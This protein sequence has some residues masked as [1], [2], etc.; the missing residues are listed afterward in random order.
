MSAPSGKPDVSLLSP[1]EPTGSRTTIS[2]GASGGYLFNEQ[3]L[4]RQYPPMKTNAE[5]RRTARIARRA[6]TPQQQ[7]AHALQACRLMATNGIFMRA[8]RIAAYIAA[9][10]ELDPKPLLA[11]ATRYNKNIYLPILQ[12]STHNSL[13]FSHYVPG[14]ELIKNQFNIPEPNI[15]KRSP[16]KTWTLDIVLMPLVA[17]D[18][19]GHRV[20]M[21]G[22]YYDRTFA[23]IKHH[24]QMHRPLL[25]GYAHECQKSSHINVQQ[26]DIPLDGVVTEKRFYKNF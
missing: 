16:I 15:R 26:W 18:A 1:L 19:Y 24:K 5:L 13:W 2:D 23:Y 9:D 21:G 11:L 7:S 20:G 10:G 25:I 4:S 22:G 17:F 12:P 8:N 6:L 3:H 14:D